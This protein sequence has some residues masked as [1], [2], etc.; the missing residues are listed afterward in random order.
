MKRKQKI[1]YLYAGVLLVL[2]I[3]TV[4]AFKEEPSGSSDFASISPDEYR[5]PL[6]DCLLSPY[7]Y[8]RTNDVVTT[9]TNNY[10]HFYSTKPRKR[11]PKTGKIRIG[12]FNLFHLGDNQAPLKNFPL[13]AE[14]IN[15]WDLV[16]GQEMMPLPSVWAESNARIYEMMLKKNVNL[17]RDWT[18]INPGYINLLRE[19]QILDPSWSLIMQSVPEGEGSTGEMAGF[20]Y[21]A[22]VVNPKEWNYC[23]SQNSIDLRTNHRAKNYGCL[24]DVPDGQS[25]LIS[26]RAFAGYFK[27]GNFDFVA[28]TAHVRFREADSP[29]DI[30]AQQ[31]EICRRKAPSRSACRVASN[32][33]GRYYEVLAVADQVNEIRKAARDLDVVYMGDFN[34]EFTRSTAEYWKAA[35]KSAPNLEVW[36]TSPTTLSVPSRKLASNYDHFVIDKNLT[37]EC[38]LSSVKSFNFVAAS[39]QSPNPVLRKIAPYLDRSY[40]ETAAQAQNAFLKTLLIS[41]SSKNSEVRPLDEKEIKKLVDKYANALE[42]M[43]ANQYGAMLELLSD[44]LPIEMVCRTDGPDDD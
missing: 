2:G 25:K 8:L 42:R 40:R 27:M 15:Q 7:V 10:V 31:S 35:L 14:V 6:D 39:P 29:N 33:V 19:L 44:H 1:R 23:D 43:D 22:S 9:C 38:D 18:V 32:L 41:P 13:M 24:V 34:L 28:L 37:K 30:A 26:R 36:Q 21:R 3:A 20:F 11:V 4:F 16:G 12:S 5:G 17:P